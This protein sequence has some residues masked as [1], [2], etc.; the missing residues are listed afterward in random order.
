MKSP[1]WYSLLS[2]LALLLVLTGLIYTIDRVF[3]YSFFYGGI[4]YSIPNLYFVY[5]A[6]RYSGAALAPLITQSFSWGESGKMAL[7]AVGFALV[8]RFVGTLNHLALFAGFLTMIIF[9]WFVASRIV[10][11][12]D[13]SSSGTVDLA[14]AASDDK[15]QKN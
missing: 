14:E 2:H 15:E 7:S 11:V 1:V 6:F 13:R 9:Q 8:F 4:V 5:Y 10:S 12:G 3:A